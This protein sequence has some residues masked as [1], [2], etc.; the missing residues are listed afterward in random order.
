M[1]AR[2]KPLE[3]EDLI[4]LVSNQRQF[5]CEK[6]RNQAAAREELLATV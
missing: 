3:P 5:M 2:E 1:I 4:E 6:R